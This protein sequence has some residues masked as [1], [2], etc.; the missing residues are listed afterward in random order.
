MG[1]AFYAAIKAQVDV[2]P[3]AVVGT[4]EM[5]KMNTWHI[6]PRPLLLLVGDSISTTG[7]SPRQMDDL[8]QRAG[9]AIA[10][11]YY[12]HSEIP[13]LRG[14]HQAEQEPGK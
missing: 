11:L 6:M 13:D 8:A 10:K 1:G 7:M 3:M 2:V 12:A 4:Y 14:Q 9:E 5:L